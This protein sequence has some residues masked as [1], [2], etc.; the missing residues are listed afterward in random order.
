VAHGSGP[1][2]QGSHSRVLG[3]SRFVGT[4]L[5]LLLASAC[6]PAPRP[7]PTIRFV[8]S[9]ERPDAAFVAVSGL[10]ASDLAALES[11]KLSADQWVRVLRVSVK[12]GGGNAAGRPPVAG[13][14]RVDQALI[15]FTPRYPFDPGRQYEVR[16]D[17]V[18]VAGVAGLDRFGA[19][20]PLVEVVGLPPVDP[21]APTTVRAVYPSA[22]VVPENLLRMYVHFSAPMASGSGVAHLSLED[23]DGREVPDP[24]LPLDGDFWNTDRTRFTVFFDPG[25]VKRELQ[26]HRQMGRP[27]RAGHSYTLV[28]HRE[29]QDGSGRPLADTFRQTFQ[30]GPADLAPLDPARWDV[31]KPAAGTRD[32]LVI[33]FPKPLD[34]ALALRALGVSRGSAAIPGDSDVDVGERRWR[35][36]PR[37]PWLPGDYSL[38][39]LTILEDVSGNRIGHAFEVEGLTKDSTGQPDVVR[40]PFRIAD[41]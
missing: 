14:Y 41:R 39:V 1:R 24:F 19:L 3:P 36:M 28:V 4:V 2:A 30:V 34:R 20:A 10:A 17:P 7:V 18:A 37:E 32:A 15:R 38:V 8:T 5:A 27:L 31:T 35:F 6:D 21:G 23:A 11:A 26:E 29:W 13:D 25:R 40:V 22:P 9:H 16:F 33:R 12:E